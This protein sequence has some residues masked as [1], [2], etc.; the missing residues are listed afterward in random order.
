LVVLSC[1]GTWSNCRATF[2]TPYSFDVLVLNSF[3][4][5]CCLSFKLSG[6]NS[7]FGNCFLYTIF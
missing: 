5:S 4:S 3:K 6:W 2:S 7:K 1:V